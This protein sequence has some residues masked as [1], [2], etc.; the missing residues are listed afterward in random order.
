MLGKPDKS[1]R[2][3]PGSHTLSH[4][5]TLTDTLIHTRA[6]GKLLLE[7]P[8]GSRNKSHKIMCHEI[9]I[10]VAW[11]HHKLLP[12]PHPLS[13]DSPSFACSLRRT[14][15]ALFHQTR[16]KESL[17]RLATWP[18]FTASLP[19]ACRL[20]ANFLQRNFGDASVPPADT[21]TCRAPSP[22]APSPPAAC[23]SHFGLDFA[24]IFQLHYF[25]WQWKWTEKENLQRCLKV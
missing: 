3:V 7:A 25:S 17:S 18:R 1:A 6:L 2:H 23:H 24:R 19:A 4:T 20:P 5:H 13:I 8:E 10:V 9:G 21:A 14:A 22:P 15:A 12:E 11:L 16:A